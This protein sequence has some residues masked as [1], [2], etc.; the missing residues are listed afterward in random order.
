M[1]IYENRLGKFK[2]KERVMNLIKKIIFTSFSYSEV[3]GTCPNCGAND[4]IIRYDGGF[5][6]RACGHEWDSK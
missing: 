6:C 2:E 5:M 1:P 4:D 3:E